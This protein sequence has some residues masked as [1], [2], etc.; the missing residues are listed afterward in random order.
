MN[1]Y[2][3]NFFGVGGIYNFVTKR[4]N[5]DGIEG[6][7]SFSQFESGSIITW[8]Y[9]SITLFSDFCIGDFHSIALTKRVQQADT[10]TKMLHISPYTFS[11]IVSKGI[12]SNCST[13]N[14]RGLVKFFHKSAESRNFS[15]CD[16]VVLEEYAAAAT[17]PRIS[18]ETSY[19][20]I[21]HEAS[22]T[23]LSVEK[24][25][26]MRSVGIKRSSAASILLR[27]F[28]REVFESLPSEMSQEVLSLLK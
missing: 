20:N 16:S 1:W 25:Y 9:P 21:E 7:I 8:K 24:I 6:T 14:Y 23:K 13:N 18:F 27:G 4:S 26:F 17:Y 2:S 11:M 10:G 28:S 22:T 12:S 5:T 15:I 19:A 3:G